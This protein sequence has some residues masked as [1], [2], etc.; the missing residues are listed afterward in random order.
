[1][2]RLPSHVMVTEVDPRPS[3]SW[4][5]PKPIA[6]VAG[7]WI[8]PPIPYAAVRQAKKKEAVCH[9][10][11]FAILYSCVGLPMIGELCHFF[12]HEIL[13]ESMTCC[14]SCVRVR[15]M[16]PGTLTPLHEG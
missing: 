11:P 6:T 2:V 7:P 1:M 14:N 4:L 15:A 16:L 12:L 9:G 5:E 10:L 8:I 13:T 3:T